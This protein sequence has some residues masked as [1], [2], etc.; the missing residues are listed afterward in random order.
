MSTLFAWS[1]TG[2]GGSYVFLL[3]W[4]TVYF[5]DINE[6][7][8]RDVTRNQRSGRY[9]A[10]HSALA[11]TTAAEK[12]GLEL[13]WVRAIAVEGQVEGCLNGLNEAFYAGDNIDL[14]IWGGRLFA[15][16]SILGEQLA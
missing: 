7:M 2:A 10:Y 16:V 9:D 3:H 13:D 15:Y 4:D 14:L 11:R 5:M 8:V 6:E 1:L 12:L